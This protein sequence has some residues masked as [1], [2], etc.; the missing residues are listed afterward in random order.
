MVEKYVEL[1]IVLKN[2]KEVNERLEV[3]FK[4][5][6]DLRE[7]KYMRGLKETITYVSYE[8]GCENTPNSKEA[9]LLNVFE[10]VKSSGGVATKCTRVL[11]KE[12]V[13]DQKRVRGLYAP[14]PAKQRM[15]DKLR[16]TTALETSAIFGFINFIRMLFGDNI[17]SMKMEEYGNNG[18]IR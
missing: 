3:L 11:I 4:G 18:R 13:S 7:R 16:D 10:I 17:I 8:G 12:M 15:R 1:N 14:K 2:N 6:S 5:L 9:D